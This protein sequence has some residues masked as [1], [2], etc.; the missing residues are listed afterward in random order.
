MPQPWETDRPLDIPGTARR[1]AER[2]PELAGARVEYLGEG[3][4]SRA[5]L[6]EGKWV[7]RLSKHADGDEDARVEIPLL[8]AIA[9]KLPV[10]IPEVAFDAGTWFGYGFLRGEPLAGRDWDPALAR[11]LAPQ[12]GQFFSALHAIPTSSLTV[13]S[14]PRNLLNM[15]AR[16]N[17][18]IAALDSFGEPGAAARERLKTA[19][20]PY[21]GPALL[22][23]N[24][25]GP[26]HALLDG[27]RLSGVIDWSDAR[28]GDP[29]T[30][31]AGVANWGGGA[32]LREVLA[33]YDGPV[34]AG[35]AGRALFQALC[36]AVYDA[37][38]GIAAAKPR[39]LRSA[40]QAVRLL[41]ND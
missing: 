20:A 25:F 17:G 2:F 38:Y 33:H 39:C 7:F 18:W 11:T 5:F 3:W 10:P 36:V 34:D 12:L 27:D 28:I 29:A 40:E 21:E 9:G 35:L 15:Q 24:D 1:I 32:F 14:G 19:P 22:V 8:K 16:A 23:H 37:H 26:E 30:D 13:P 4:D 6:V 41:L 31:F